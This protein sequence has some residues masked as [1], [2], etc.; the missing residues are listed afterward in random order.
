MKLALTCLIAVLLD[1]LLGDGPRRRALAGFG[2][3]AVRLEPLL[4]GP[5]TLGAR[6]RRWLGG[7]ALALLIAPLAVLAWWLSSLP[8][9]GRLVDLGLLYVS[10]DTVG[11][12]RRAKAVARALAQGDLALA[13]QRVTALVHQDTASMDEGAISAATVETLLRGG[14]TGLVGA[15]FWFLAGGAGALAVYCSAR[16]LAGIWGHPTP[17]YGDFGQGAARLGAVLNWIPAR[18]TALGYILLGDREAAW[19]CWRRRQGGIRWNHSVEPALAA[20]AG[21]LGLQLGG[22][23]RYFGTLV[24]RPA[25]GEGVLPAAVDILR[26]R[27]LL[28]ATLVLWLALLLIVG[29][30]FV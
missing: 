17:R 26:A 27:R 10:L 6:A 1:R 15:L 22:P 16:Y 24:I 19:R 4:Y 3:L 8:Y 13:R 23:V 14:C 11:E 12:A 2:W 7:L 30:W 9:L 29:V 28:S 25:V 5:P 18:L 21:A 20:G